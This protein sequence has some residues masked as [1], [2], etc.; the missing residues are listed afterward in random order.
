MWRKPAAEPLAQAAV[1]L[2]FARVAERWVTHVVPEPDRL[3]Q[4]L[5]QPQRPRDDAGDA[6][7]L[8]RVRDPRPVVVA[9]RVDEDLGL[10]FQP[11]ERLRVDDP[12]AI[13]LERR[14][15]AALVLLASAAPRLVGADGE[16]RER[17]LLLRADA[18][19]E[20][21]RDSS[22]QLRHHRSV[23]ALRTARRRQ[24]L[25]V[26]LAEQLVDVLPISFVETLDQALDLRRHHEQVAGRLGRGVAVRVRGALG[27]EDGGAGWSVDNLA[28]EQEAQA[29]LEHVPRLVVGVVDV[30]RR[31]P[32]R[33]AWIAPLDDDEV[34]H[35]AHRM[36]GTV[37]PSAD[38]A[39]PVT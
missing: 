19:L 29:A 2:V 12:V 38:Q 23:V 39:A 10:P 22:G 18:R 16:R 6:G 3:G 32:V 21:V 31:D 26:V 11:P 20:G 4:V 13:A 24:E 30:E 34:A 36:I 25:R 35:L 9:G 17:R 33:P 27:R 5:V 15:Y 7:R 8:E 14:P 28:A 37:P 1:E